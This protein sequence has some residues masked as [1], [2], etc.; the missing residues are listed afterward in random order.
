MNQIYKF[1]LAI[2]LSLVLTSLMPIG[3]LAIVD[4]DVTQTSSKIQEIQDVQERKRA[5]TTAK[6]TELCSRYAN[7]KIKT[8]VEEKR[9]NLSDRLRERDGSLT[10]KRSEWDSK[11]SEA[12]SI[13]DS[14]RQEHYAKLLETAQTDAQKTA[15]ETFRLAV[16]KAV[17]ERRQSQD[18]ARN[19]YRSGVDSLVSERK[20]ELEGAA[21]EFKQSVE[22]ALSKAKTACENG[23]P[24]DTVKAG[25]KSD[26][27]EAKAE[28]KSA[29]ESIPNL[30]DSIKALVEQRKSSL[31]SAK[32][33]FESALE[34]ARADLKESFAQTEA[35]VNP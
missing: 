27:D 19:S 26:L 34:K 21:N 20:S 13:A 3:A 22:D 16:E 6:L 25:L 32:T 10:S 24:I 7:T 5:E 15:V 35:P 9:G 29:T 12:R 4:Q 23:T 17:S 33:V 31:D 1:T 18:V 30:S 14:R 11:R 2:S 8:D 28:L